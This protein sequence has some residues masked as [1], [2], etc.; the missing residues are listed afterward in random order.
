MVDT[1]DYQ[2]CGGENGYEGKAFVT[3]FLA[4]F[5]FTAF[6]SAMPS[7]ACASRVLYAMGRDGQLPKRFFGTLHKKYNTPV[8]N[9]LLISGFSLLALVLSLTTVASF[10]NFGAFLAFTC[11]NLSVISHYFIK[12]KRR[13]LKGFILYFIIPL[14]EVMVTFELGFTCKSTWGGFG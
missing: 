8:N 2:C 9:I 5:G 12:L 7:Q 13:S 11:V 4:V 14:L 1:D 3:F 10:I 6:G